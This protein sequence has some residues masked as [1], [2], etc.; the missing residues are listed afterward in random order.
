MK[1]RY[2]IED[3]EIEEHKFKELVYTR[4]SKKISLEHNNSLIEKQKEVKVVERLKQKEELLQGRYDNIK[5]LANS[6][7]TEEKEEFLNEALAL[8]EELEKVQTKLSKEEDKS[9]EID[10]VFEKLFDSCVSG[11]DVPALKKAMEQY[12]ISFQEML[13]III[14]FTEKDKQKKKKG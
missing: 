7:E 3:L 2:P 12:G 10:S 5:Q 4:P 9:F 11:K 14:K 1:Y 6:A 8:L 13:E